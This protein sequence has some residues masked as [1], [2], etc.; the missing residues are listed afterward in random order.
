MG[1]T[2]LGWPC[3]PGSSLPETLTRTAGPE[4]LWMGWAEIKG[5]PHVVAPVSW[6]ASR[7]FPHN[8]LPQ[9]SVQWEGS[10]PLAVPGKTAE[11]EDLGDTHSI[12]LIV[13]G[14]SRGSGSGGKWPLPY[15]RFTA[16]AEEWASWPG[17]SRH[18]QELQDRTAAGGLSQTCFHR[19]LGAAVP[20]DPV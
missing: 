5:E 20:W 9:P 1:I 13:L 8:R 10:Q 4:R 19:T 2:P 18:M 6:W 14:G 12:C 11:W 7:S 3:P 15:C 16:F 17:T